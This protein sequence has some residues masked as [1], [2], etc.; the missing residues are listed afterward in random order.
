MKKQQKGFERNIWEKFI[1]TAIIPVMLL[2]ISFICFML[3][4]SG[5]LLKRKTNEAGKFIAEKLQQMDGYYREV[6]MQMSESTEIRNYLLNGEKSYQVFEKYYRSVNNQEIKFQMVLI[7][8][9]KNMVLKSNIRDAYRVDYSFLPLARM[10]EEGEHQAVRIFSRSDAEE[11]T[12]YYGYGTVVYEQDQPVGY[13]IYYVSSRQMSSL[14]TESG[15]EEIVITNQFDT[16]LVTTSE[17]AR[18]PFNKLAYVQDDSG[19][20]MVN[21]NKY[22]ISVYS[23]D[24]AGLKVYA[25]GS[26]FYEHYFL[27]MIPP[28][29]IIV[30][31][32][33]SFLMYRMSRDMSR[34]VTEPIEKLMDAV[35]Q[36]SKGEFNINVELDTGDEFELLAEEYNRM[37]KKVDNLIETNNQ[38]AELQRKAEF[39]IIRNQF[40]PHFI[41]NVLETLRYMVFVD[42]KE[43]EHVILALSKFLRYNIYNQDKFVPLKEDMEHMEDFLMLHKARFQERMT[44]EIIMDEAAGEIFV[45]K[46]FIQPFAENSIKYGFRSRNQFHVEIRAEIKDEGLVV[47]VKDNGGGM[48][49]EKYREVCHNLELEQYPDDH[50]GLYNI[51]RIL[52]M[53]YGKEYGL[54]LNNQ[55]GE[56]LEV[57][58]AI[59]ALES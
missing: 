9:D 52:K 18:N 25:L 38:M 27:R 54:S 1:I 16:V 22:Y 30:A 40:N 34:R 48:T 39:K 28:F 43:A 44:Y 53:I 41:F 3:V 4:S 13:I 8:M 29:L 23:L 26:R 59:P 42:Q 57:I 7:D 21:E 32:V 45:P 6:C 56:G 37:V 10:C 20:V 2:L 11:L 14:L 55:E 12:Y 50:I 33:L 24:D 35:K 5:M 49:E 36:T 46:F 15:A 31:V 19:N 51:N 58:V 17:T 47:S